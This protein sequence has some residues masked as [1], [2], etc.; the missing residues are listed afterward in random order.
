[1][2]LAMAGERA[3]LHCEVRGDGKGTPLLLLHGL[4]GSGRDW[5]ALAGR[6]SVGRRLLLPDLPGHGRSPRRGRVAV[7]DMAAAVEAL[8]ERQGEEAVHAVGLSLGG[9]VALALALRCPARVRSLTL[10]NAFARLRPAGPRGL[11]RLLVRLCLLA[12]APMPV[13]AAHVA[14]GLFPRPDQAHLYR[15]ARTAL[16]RTS[17]RDYAAA[18]AALARFDVRARLGEV[19]CP[20]LVVAGERDTTV[21]LSA[22][23]ALAA[24]IAGA[25]LVVV[26]GSGHATTHDEPERFAE[27]LLEFLAGQ[28]SGRR[29]PVARRAPPRCNRSR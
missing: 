1:M 9:C 20:V 15:E 24:G 22:K 13:L 3:A 28:E 7:E 25:R 11:A 23:Q 21:P 2:A 12:A 19:R 18:V 5:E 16:A 27:V 29:A 6:L 14:R 17:R 4:G 26:P 8:L 10:V